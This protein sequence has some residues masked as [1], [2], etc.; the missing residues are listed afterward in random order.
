MFDYLQLSFKLLKIIENVKTK[1]MF[2]TGINAK[3]KLNLLPQASDKTSYP[4]S[5]LTTV[6]GS[7][8]VRAAFP[9]L[10]RTIKLC[11]GHK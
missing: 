11:T 5:H 2:F 9:D 1:H 8:Q 10:S 4:Q 7:Y 3:K 6:T